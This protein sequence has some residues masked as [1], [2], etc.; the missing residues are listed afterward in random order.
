[1]HETEAWKRYGVAALTLL[2]A[3][4]LVVLYPP[5]RERGAFVL[6]LGAVAVSAWYGGFGPAVSTALASALFAA[7]YVLPPQGVLGLLSVEDALR[8]ALF[9]FVG[10]AIA[11]LYEAKR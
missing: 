6:C 11:S 9:L 1:M 2:V 3:I 5:F 7:I 8:L 4:A 10:G